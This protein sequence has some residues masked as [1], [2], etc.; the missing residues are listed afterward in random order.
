MSNTVA[1][2]V[3][4]A[5]LGHRGVDGVAISGEDTGGGPRWLRQ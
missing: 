4:R 1:P 5:G 3:E 2:T